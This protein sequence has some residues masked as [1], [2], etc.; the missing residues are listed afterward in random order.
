MSEPEDAPPPAPMAWLTAH[1]YAHRGLFDAE[2]GVPENSQAA[3]AAAMKAGHG[4]DLDC[5]LSADGIPMVFHDDSLDRM[6]GLSG[7]VLRHGSGKLRDVV[8]SGSSETIPTLDDVL[9]QVSGAV[10]LIIEAK[11]Q[12]GASS[13]R[14]CL[15]IRR[16][17][18]GY[19]HPVAIMSQDAQIVAWFQRNA[20]RIGRGLVVTASARKRTFLERMGWQSHVDS[21]RTQPHF[22][23]VPLAELPSALSTR[24]RAAG[25]PI[26]TGPVRGPEDAAHAA[27]HADTYTF[28]ASAQPEPDEPA[29]EDDVAA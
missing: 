1:R 7:P 3:F 17:L 13:T 28:A 26:L 2:A 15:A 25:V 6:T 4:I 27:A 22:M 9:W 23:A 16:A 24:M 11:P 29:T 12:P 20:P 5:Q 10:P 18:E 19:P 21:W 8:L 14:L